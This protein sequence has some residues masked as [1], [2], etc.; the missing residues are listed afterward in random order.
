MKQYELTIRRFDASGNIVEHYSDG[1]L[2][3]EDTLEK[4]EPA[5]PNS[6]FIWGPNVPLGFMTGRIEDA[7][8]PLP[9]PKPQTA[10]DGDDV[11]PVPVRA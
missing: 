10:L 6:L 5:A 7:G 2:V 1:D 9:L 3:N 11:T 8:I 4:R